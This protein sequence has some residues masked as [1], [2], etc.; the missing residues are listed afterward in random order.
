MKTIYSKSIKSLFTNLRIS[1]FFVFAFFHLST[2]AQVLSFTD[3]SLESGTA[4]SQGA[5]YRFTN[6]CSPG[7]VDALVTVTELNNVGLV[8][9]D[10]RYTGADK[11]LQPMLSSNNG[12]GDHY[13]IFTVAFVNAGSNV[14][15]SI[16]NYSSTFYGLNGNH[17]IRKYASSMLPN[18]SWKYAN[19]TP[20]VR[21]AQAGHLIRGESDNFDLGQPIDTA[22]H[23]N[24]FIVDAGVTGSVTVRFGFAQDA[25]WS[26]NEQFSALLRGFASAQTLPVKLESFNAQL[27]SGK[28]QLKW[29]TSMEEN[30]SH[31]IVER[32]AN[33]KDFTE[34]AMVFS[35]ES[36]KYYQYT[37]EL[38]SKGIFYYRLKMVDMSQKSQASVIRIIKAVNELASVNIQAYPNPV[39]N[40]LRITVPE[41]WQNK[42]VSYVL[43]SADGILLKSLINKTANQTEKFNMSAF[44]PGMYILKVSSGDQVTVK[45]IMKTI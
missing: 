4:L 24:A 26:G 25:S 19:A 34:I 35:N 32:S 27:Q 11:A 17:Q 43:Y 2:S 31:F 6:V 40:E 21:V 13:A 18:S 28:V 15:A 33:G 23:S 7:N 39:V 44:K 20:K 8:H 10:G 3:F 22:N 30:F 45:K 42:E 29:I 1:V 41:L 36:S 14:P 16:F 9:I 37:D 38:D 5:V 12:P